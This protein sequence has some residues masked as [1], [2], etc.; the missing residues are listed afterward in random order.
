MG[1]EEAP[2]RPIIALVA[3]KDNQGDGHGNNR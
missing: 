1:E 3:F 2:A